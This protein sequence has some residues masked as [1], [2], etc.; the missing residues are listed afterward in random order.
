MSLL[1]KPWRGKKKGKGGILFLCKP[2]KKTPGSYHSMVIDIRAF[3]L[4]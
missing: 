1:P 4:I 2:T 3:R